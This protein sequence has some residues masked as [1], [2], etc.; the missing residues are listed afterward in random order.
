MHRHPHFD[1]WLH[2]DD[3]LRQWL[4]SEVH[5][6]ETV[7]EWPLSCVQRL[8]L[9]DGST[10]IYKVQAPPTV[11][12]EFY[13]HAAGALLVPAQAIAQPHGPAALL[14][15]DIA[16]PRLCDMSRSPAELAAVGWATVTQIGTLAGALPVVADLSTAAKWQDYAETMVAELAALVDS[17]VFVQ[18]DRAL[19]EQIAALSASP[20]V[21]G[22]FATPVGYVHGDLTGTN[23]F[24]GGEGY[25]L[26]DW[27]RPIRGPVALDVVALLD[28]ARCDPGRYVAAGIVQLFYL[29]R[30]A[31]FTQCALRWFPPGAATY[32][33]AIVQLAAKIA[34][35]GN[36]EREVRQ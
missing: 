31:W 33:G 1:L 26:I 4:G 21:L 16:A 23:L 19:V 9:A 13:A 15:A 2:D 8:Y 18:V 20:A 5:R 25:R 17:G 11:E 35:L 6:R 22:A 14:L 30:M 3:E 32:D 10:R 24:V 29:L 36:G 27:Q 12:P 28:S 34:A 7:H